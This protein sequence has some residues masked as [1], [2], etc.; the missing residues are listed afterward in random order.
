VPLSVPSKRFMAIY[1]EGSPKD[2]MEHVL[3]PTKRR[4][5][6]DTASDAIEI[7]A[8]ADH[9]GYVEAEYF[10]DGQRVGENDLYIGI[11][12]LSQW[13]VDVV[14]GIDIGTTNTAVGYFVDG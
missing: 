12:Q 7:R 14:I 6:L 1:T 3:N 9:R 2:Q 10:S 13:S 5:D 8:R 11:G 4:F